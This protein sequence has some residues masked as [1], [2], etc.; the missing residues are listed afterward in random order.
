L[1]RSLRTVLSGARSGSGIALLL[2]MQ[3]NR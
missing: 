2:L 3:T 1:L